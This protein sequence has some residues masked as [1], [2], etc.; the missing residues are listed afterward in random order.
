MHVQVD[1]QKAELIPDLLE[2]C[3]HLT[4]LWQQVLMEVEPDAVSHS[5]A[6]VCCET[7]QVAVLY[8]STL[9]SI[10]PLVLFSCPARSLHNSAHS[11]YVD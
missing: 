9:I 1:L 10:V 2:D 3:P 11:I 7:W 8:V 4:R 6:F 5:S